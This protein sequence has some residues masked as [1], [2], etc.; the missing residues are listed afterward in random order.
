MTVFCFINI[1]DLYAEYRC[2]FEKLQMFV[3]LLFMVIFISVAYQMLSGCSL[4][5]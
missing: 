1:F 4:A 3:E 5:T 2:I